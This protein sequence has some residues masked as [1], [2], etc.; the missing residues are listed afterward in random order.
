[1]V[2]HACSGLLRADDGALCAECR[3]RLRA[4]L[5]AES[6]PDDP[7]PEPDAKPESEV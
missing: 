5:A 7:D 3:E 4:A 6:P 1:M 2:C